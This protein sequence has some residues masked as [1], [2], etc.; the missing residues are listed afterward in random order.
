MNLVQMLI[1]AFESLISNK[2]R[3]GLT[4]LGIVIGVAAVISMLAIGAGAQT[5]ID[6]LDQQHWHQ[7]DL[8]HGQRPTRP[9]PNR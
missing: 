8:C 9:T 6:Q 2:L 1:E 3:S 5:S 7:P 4:M